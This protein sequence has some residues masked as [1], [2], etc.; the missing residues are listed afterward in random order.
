M[1]KLNKNELITS[2]KIYSMEVSEGID[3]INIFSSIPPIKI[4]EWNDN[5]DRWDNGHATYERYDH[6]ELWIIEQKGKKYIIWTY[7]EQG[8]FCSDQNF[9]SADH[10][11]NCYDLSL[12]KVDTNSISGIINIVQ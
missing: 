11:W 5:Y 6:N 1:E 7:D 4:G 8:D 2:E 12:F 9:H 3:T 10:N